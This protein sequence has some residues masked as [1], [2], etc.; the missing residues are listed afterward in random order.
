[1]A[2]ASDCRQHLSYLLCYIPDTT[3]LFTPDY[4]L[5]VR[6]GKGRQEL[7]QHPPTDSEKL[8]MEKVGQLISHIKW[9]C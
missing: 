5:F 7:V 6:W 9:L 1:M 3:H 2:F 4:S 8:E